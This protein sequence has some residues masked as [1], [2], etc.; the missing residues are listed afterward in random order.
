MS[1]NYPI[2]DE[3]TAPEAARPLLAGAKQKLGFIPNLYGV[4]AN[5]P[6]LLDA[7]FKVGEAFQRSSFTPTEQQVV[8]LAVSAANGCGYCRAAHQAVAA[9]QG[10]DAGVARAAAEGQPIDD[11]RLEALRAFAAH[12]VET[13][14]W[15]DEAAIEAFLSAGY[16]PSQVLEVVLG[17][18]MK[19][20]SNYT[21]HIAHTPIDAAFQGAGA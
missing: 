13:R 1:L 6:A 14:G 15:P 10:I 5:A 3:T 20:L 2:H 19:T 16:S 7:Y 21:N 17:V 12:V 11:P 4:M 18:G 8:L 9:M